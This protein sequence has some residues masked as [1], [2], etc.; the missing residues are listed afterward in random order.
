M[1]VTPIVPWPRRL[2]RHVDYVLTVTYHS[3]DSVEPKTWCLVRSYNEFR[4]FRKRLV[5]ALTRGHYCRT[6]CPWLCTFLESYYPKSQ[7][8]GSSLVRVIDRRRKK[9]TRSLATIR[10]FSI[11]RANHACS[12]VMHNVALKLL[13]F[14]VGKKQEVDQFCH[15]E[16]PA[17]LRLLLQRWHKGDFEDST[18]SH[19][20][21]DRLLR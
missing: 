9:L 21:Q 18:S 6:D 12:V 1:D 7:L 8:V 4:V 2:Y 15:E 14:A 20:A 11:T 13:E 10:S 3:Q 19:D 17:W 16:V 5:T